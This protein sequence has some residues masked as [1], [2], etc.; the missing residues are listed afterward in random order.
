MTTMPSPDLNDVRI[1]PAT[2]EALRAEEDGGYALARALGVAAPEQWPPEFGG[3]SYARAL[4]GQMAQWDDMARFGGWYI[5]A[6]GRLVGFCGFK[7]PPDTSGLVE[8]GYSVAAPYQRRGYAKAA[9]ALLL[10]EAFSD[11]RVAAVVATTLPERT[12]SVRVLERCGFELESTSEKVL[13]F[14]K[15]RPRPAQQSSERP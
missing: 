15:R 7:G 9:V 11:P 3:P 4:L 10:A 2:A 12:A 1:V 13:K 14:M 8:I 5:I 6:G